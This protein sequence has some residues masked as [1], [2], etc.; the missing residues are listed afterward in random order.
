MDTGDIIVYFTEF[1]PIIFDF[2]RGGVDVREIYVN[3]EYKAN[4]M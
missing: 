3:S 1:V 4:T 2:C